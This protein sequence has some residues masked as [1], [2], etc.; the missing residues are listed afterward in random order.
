MDLRTALRS[1]KSLDDLP[2][3]MVQLGHLPTWEPVPAEAWDSGS[4]R[5]FHVTAVGQSGDIPWLGMTSGS[6]DRDAVALARRIQKRG[7]TAMVLAIDPARRR[8][9]VTV[10]YDR[11][12]CVSL[13]LDSADE[14]SV[15]SLARLAVAA[16]GGSY[17]YLARAADAL[18]AEPVSRRFFRQFRATLDHM[19]ARVPGQ[20]PIE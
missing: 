7:Q 11:C 4:H 10:T 5:V 8:L 16:D 6:A 9:A 15:T 1:V 18:A 13:S 20:I 2:K 14:E 12:P 19:M 3:L 17:A